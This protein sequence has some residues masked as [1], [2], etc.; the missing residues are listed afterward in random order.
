MKTTLFVL[1]TVFSTALW[2]QQA[3]QGAQ[4]TGVQMSGSGCREASASATLS[5]DSRELSILFD[6]FIL[7]ANASLVN[8]QNLRAETKC[9]VAI[10]F[11]IPHGWQ[12]ALTG[13]DYRGFAA[14]PAEAVGYQRFLYQVAG[15]P[16]VS[17]R[18]AT[19]RGPH[20]DNY[21]F[22]AA[23]KPG[24]FAWTQCGVSNV[25]LPMT[26]VIGVA[27]QRRGHYP[28]ATVAL[29]SQDLSLSQDFQ[30]AWQ[31]CM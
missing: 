18:E 23:Q 26:A 8:Q 22:S 24:R 25:R 13:V 10:D 5:P 20:N 30:V 27:Y 17:M 15:M 1:A 12:M 31:R 9:T 29:D 19:F 4:I 7:D 3:P 28:P 21:T 16:A 14:I 6:N 2:A 11:A